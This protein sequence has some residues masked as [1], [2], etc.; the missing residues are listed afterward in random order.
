MNYIILELG[1]HPE[2]TKCIC[3]NRSILT[4]K[5][6]IYHVH[7]PSWFPTCA[8]TFVRTVSESPMSRITTSLLWCSRTNRAGKTTI[9]WLWLLPPFLT[10][11]QMDH[12]FWT[13]DM[14]NYPHRRLSYHLH[15]PFIRVAKISNP[16]ESRLPLVGSIYCYGPCPHFAEHRERSQDLVGRM[17]LRSRYFI[18]YLLSFQIMTYA[19]SRRI[20]ILK[21]LGTLKGIESCRKE[22]I[23]SAFSLSAVTVIS[24]EIQ[25]FSQRRK[26]RYCKTSPARTSHFER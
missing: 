24:P 2:T 17:S 12:E 20:M 5:L 23:A 22:Y 16:N 14:Y 11:E 4:S 6:T 19:T 13:F 1:R 10:I 8:T 21:Q 15:F 9:I 18:T 26:Q 25:S 3:Q 7:V